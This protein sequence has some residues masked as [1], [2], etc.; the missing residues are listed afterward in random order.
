MNLDAPAYVRRLAKL[1]K[2]LEIAIAAAEIGRKKLSAIAEN[3][4]QKA[5][6]YHFVTN[7]AQDGVAEVQRMLKQMGEV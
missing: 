7:F 2:R 5:G 3:N 1:E 6:G 4:W